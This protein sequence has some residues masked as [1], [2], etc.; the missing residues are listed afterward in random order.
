VVAKVTNP[1]HGLRSSEAEHSGSLPLIEALVELERVKNSRLPRVVGLQEEP[2]FT[3]GSAG[4]LIHWGD[5]NSIR[6]QLKAEQD[7]ARFETY[8]TPD[9]SWKTPLFD[10]AIARLKVKG[11]G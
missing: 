9:G 6:A 5:W 11:V 7:R 8:Q 1:A 4:C 3:N 10:Q 2:P